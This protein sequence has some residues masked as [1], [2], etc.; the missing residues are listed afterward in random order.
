MVPCVSEEEPAPRWLVVSDPGVRSPSGPDLE[1]RFPGAPFPATKLRRGRKAFSNI[2]KMEIRSGEC[3]VR[4]TYIARRD[5]RGLRGERYRDEDLACRILESGP[6][7]WCLRLSGC[8][9]K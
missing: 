5:T 3:S 1:L 2:W 9:P 6:S 4:Q 8:L 7:C